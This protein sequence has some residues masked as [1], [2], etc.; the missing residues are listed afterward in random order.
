MAGVARKFRNL[1]FLRRFESLVTRCAR[2]VG[3]VIPRRA[4]ERDDVP[5]TLKVE[6]RKVSFE[7]GRGG[8]PFGEA[9]ISVTNLSVDILERLTI[10]VVLKLDGVGPVYTVEHTYRAHVEPGDFIELTLDLGEVPL[11]DCPEGVTTEVQVLASRHV[12]KTLPTYVLPESST[13]I[14]AIEDPFMLAREIV[15]QRIDIAVS[16]TFFGNKG[17]ARVMYVM[18]N[19][20]GISHHGLSIVTRFYAVT[21]ELIGSDER[22]FDI[23]ALGVSRV[24]A[25]VGFKR[26]GALG[27]SRFESEVDGFEDIARGASSHRGIDG[28]SGRTNDRAEIWEGEEVKGAFWMDR[29]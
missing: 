6:V 5:Q 22:V 11:E 18:R 14:C 25:K 17:W 15:V 26:S 16:R 20:S 24:V 13:G 21:G 7:E 3:N 27:A 2:V 29:A 23:G 12:N 10:S 1:P 19:D 8:T 9:Q 28:M 4:V